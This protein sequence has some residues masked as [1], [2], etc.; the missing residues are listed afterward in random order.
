MQ[1]PQNRINTTKKDDGTWALD[2]EKVVTTFLD[3]YHNLLGSSNTTKKIEPRRI[4]KGNILSEIQQQELNP[5]LNSEDIKAALFSIADDISPG[6]DGYSSCFFQ[7]SWDIV[8]QD[9]ITAVQDFFRN[10]KIFK[11]INVTAITLIPN[12]SS[13]ATVEDYRPIACCS[14]LYKVVTKLICS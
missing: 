6:I 12:I 11:N 7:R 5:S 1:R 13:F 8:G 10:G 3:F 4:A 9:I 14:I 2:S